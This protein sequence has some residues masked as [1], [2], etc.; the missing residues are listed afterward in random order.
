MA[1]HLEYGRAAEQLARLHLESHGLR[2]IVSNYSCKYGELDL[3]VTNR[4]ILII[5]EVRYR[6]TTRIMDPVASISP[7]KCQRIARATEHFL[8]H[9]ERWRSHPIRF[10]VIG[11]SGPFDDVHMNW[12]QGAFTMDDLFPD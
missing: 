1:E 12:I 8:Q 11:C 10:D 6:K 5:V 2:H 7:T 3:I 4:S 9:H